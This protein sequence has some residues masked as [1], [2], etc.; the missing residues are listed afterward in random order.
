MDITKERV[1][2]M[3]RNLHTKVVPFATVVEHFEQGLVYLQKAERP[4]HRDKAH[5]YAALAT[6]H[7][8]AARTCS[9][10]GFEIYFGKPEESVEE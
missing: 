1:S 9:L 8:D 7:F 3:N 6:A 2:K 5:I 10:V 4:V